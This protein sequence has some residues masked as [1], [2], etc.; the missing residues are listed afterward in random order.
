[1]KIFLVAKR[2]SE[3]LRV[4]PRLR[5]EPRRAE[6]K[7]RSN[8]S[9]NSRRAEF[10]CHRRQTAKVF[11]SRGTR[12]FVTGMR[13]EPEGRTT[14]RDGARSRQ[15]SMATA[16]PRR[17]SGGTPDAAQPRFVVK[18]NNTPNLFASLQTSKTQ[19]EALAGAF[20]SVGV[21]PERER[22]SY[23]NYSLFTVHCSLFH[24]HAET[25][26]RRALASLRHLER[27]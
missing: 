8:L 25:P 3:A 22:L 6:Q 27:C 20:A 26:R 2:P 4:P 21:N 9:A 16:T 1:M 12:A 19:A 23:R 5:V 17:P 18:K 15:A 11:V 24:S 10:S 7:R 14:R 13:G